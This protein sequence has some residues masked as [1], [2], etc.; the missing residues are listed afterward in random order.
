MEVDILNSDGKSSG[1][2]TLPDPIFAEKKV[3]KSLLHEVVRAYLANQRSGTHKAKTRSEVSGSMKK[4]WK[5][6]HTGRARAGTS[7]SPLWKGGGIIHGPVPR[8]Y[9]ISVPKSKLET[10]LVHA[11]SSKA[12]AGN[13]MVS[14]LPALK[15]AKTKT[16][17]TWLK[18]L[19]IP[20]KSLL[21]VDKKDDKFALASRNMKDFAWIE[22]KHLHPYHVLKAKKI[23]FTPEALQCL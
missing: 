14:A 23:V 16:V 9:H 10:A 21:I 3:S 8:S 11:L 2:A 7:T 1:K 22:C 17:A 20:A 15:E 19:S 4:P 6:K 13:V 5:Q 18:K 12:S